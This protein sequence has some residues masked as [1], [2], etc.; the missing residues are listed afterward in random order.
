MVIPTDQTCR[1]VMRREYGGDG[2]AP[3][4]TKIAIVSVSSISRSSGLFQHPDVGG[5][6]AAIGKARNEQQLGDSSGK[7]SGG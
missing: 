3:R 1:V 7:R 2:S 4:L 5:H 6:I